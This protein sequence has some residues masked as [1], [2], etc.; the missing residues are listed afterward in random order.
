[1]QLSKSWTNKNIVFLFVVEGFPFSFGLAKKQP[2]FDSNPSL[3]RKEMK[4]DI[5]YYFFF[6]MHRLRIAQGVHGPE[7]SLAQIQKVQEG[8]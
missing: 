7:I 1:M 2:L 6:K 4:S 8:M 3:Q 5:W